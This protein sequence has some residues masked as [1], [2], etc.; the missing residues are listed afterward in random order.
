[1]VETRDCDRPQRGMKDDEDVRDDSCGGPDRAVR[2]GLPGAGAGL[3]QSSHHPDR[4]LRRRR[5]QRFD[6]AQRRREDEQDP[7]PSNRHR[8]SRRRGRQHRHAG[9]RQGGAR[10]LHPRTRRHRHARDQ[11]DALRQCRLRPAQGFRAGRPH[12]NQRARGL[13]APCALRTVHRGADRA[14]EDAASISAPSTSRPWPASSSPTFPT[15]AARR[16]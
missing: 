7:R 15:R 2:R 12:R 8:E 1:M 10:R 14:R 4:P 5:R 6:G 13:R 3:P 11:S 9:D 16:R